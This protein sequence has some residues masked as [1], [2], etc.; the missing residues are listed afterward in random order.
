[1]GELY[2][3][4]SIPSWGERARNRRPI[5][6]SADRT[7]R[8]FSL[9]LDILLTEMRHGV[10]LPMRMRFPSLLAFMLAVAVTSPA[11][12]TNFDDVSATPTS[13]GPTTVGNQPAGGIG[14]VGSGTTTGGAGGNGG[15]VATTPVQQ[16]P[17]TTP[18]AQTPVAQAPTTQT[19]GSRPAQAVTQD[20]G[21]T[22]QQSTDSPQLAQRKQQIWSRLDA[23]NKEG[24]QQALQEALKEN[25]ADADLQAMAQLAQKHEMTLDGKALAAKMAALGSGRD[26]GAAL[27]G[28]A[29][30]DAAAKPALASAL[31]FLAAPKPALMAAPPDL[32]ALS[33]AT[34]LKIKLRDYSGAEQELTGKIQQSPENWLA[35]HYRALMRRYLKKFSDAEKDADRALQLNAKDWAAHDVKALIRLDNRDSK[36]AITES[37]LALQ[38]NPRDVNAL[39]NRAHALEAEGRHDEAAAD[40]NAA[41]AIDPSFR[42]TPTDLGAGARLTQTHALYA[43][44]MG[45]AL[46]LFGLS[47]A[48]KRAQTTRAAAARPAMRA[49]DK[50]HGGVT[51][52]RI[53]RRIGQGGMGVVYEAQDETLQ[54][55]VA[56]KRMRD[57][58]AG[59]P[60]ERRRFMR[61][62]RLVA[63][64]RH[65]GIVQIFQ[66]V[67]Q[68]PALYLVFEYLPGEGLDA[69]LDKRGGK[70]SPSEALPLLRQIAE[71]LDYA[72]AQGVVHQDL[73]PSNVVITAGAAKV[74]DFGI[75]RRV[76]DALSTLSRSEALGTPAYMAPEQEQ[77]IV[78][79]KADLFAF[80][81]C[82]YEMLSGKTPFGR[83][84]G[85]FSKVDGGFTPLSAAS[86]LPESVDAA[87]AAALSADP[88]GRPSS[89]CAFVASLDAALAQPRA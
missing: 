50:E 25:P 63:N 24:A 35:Y 42:E 14:K 79:P 57:E 28:T 40:L 48:A 58:I 69:L 82:A 49:E 2:G 19:G 67:E 74:M 80:G 47:F 11:S 59:D 26:A 17:T 66:V 29:G 71:A 39:A 77:G 44:A 72:H 20:G 83:G 52:F 70:L 56:L 86:G 85:G 89:A 41:L 32:R 21:A 46:L 16:T 68:E 18:V 73:K 88:A 62:A 76:Q 1:M 64:L 84:G 51:G 87:V 27:G 31:G 38:L 65:R 30:Q 53:L 7:F 43:A 12:G 78:T 3:L 5:G 6:L 36:G 75:A 23:G 37:T 13:G 45:L 15:A 60:R 61:E 33:P 22:P 9:F 54:R 10:N 8:K 34:V 55:K 4:K 81:V